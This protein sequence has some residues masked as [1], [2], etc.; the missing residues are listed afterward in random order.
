MSLYISD[1]IYLVIVLHTQ[2][3]KI[4]YIYKDLKLVRH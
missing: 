4:K 3:L 2:Q 1:G